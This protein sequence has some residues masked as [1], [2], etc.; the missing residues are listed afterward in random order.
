MKKGKISPPATTEQKI[1]HAVQEVVWRPDKS[2]IVKKFHTTS[3]PLG[4]R[5]FCSAKFFIRW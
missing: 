2:K 4:V 1:E 3:T 5:L